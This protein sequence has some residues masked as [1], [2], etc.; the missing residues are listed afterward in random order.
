[1]QTSAGTSTAAFARPG[2]GE[3]GGLAPG[4]DRESATDPLEETLA[5]G[6]GIRPG[7]LIGFEVSGR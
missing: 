7:N 3:G 6:G 5:G 2:P 1:M 4:A